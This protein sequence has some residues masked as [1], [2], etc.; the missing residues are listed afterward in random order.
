MWR[1]V[2][3]YELQINLEDLREKFKKLEFLILFSKK[4]FI[5]SLKINVLPQFSGKKLKI[6]LT[7]RGK[8]LRSK[9]LGEIH[10]LYLW[11]RWVD[12]TLTT[13]AIAENA[14]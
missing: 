10:T 4:L 9:N 3:I 7:S 14:A 5:F 11:L 8:N 6:Y 1:G 2:K 13:S 12:I